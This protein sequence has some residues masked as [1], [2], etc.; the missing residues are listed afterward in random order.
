MGYQPSMPIK[1]DKEGRFHIYHSEGGENFASWLTRINMAF[2]GG[3][4][5]LLILEITSPC[6]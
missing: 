6:K 2:I 1:F 5:L 4:S 3:N